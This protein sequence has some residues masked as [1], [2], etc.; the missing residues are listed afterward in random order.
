VGGISKSEFVSLGLFIGRKAGDIMKKI[1]LNIMLIVCIII[2]CLYLF[3]TQARAQWRTCIRTDLLGMELLI[4]EGLVTQTNPIFWTITPRFNWDRFG[5]PIQGK[6]P[7]MNAVYPASNCGELDSLSLR[8]LRS[9]NVEICGV[10]GKLQKNPN[11]NN[12]NEGFFADN[13]P[14][15][16][17]MY[18]EKNS[19]IS[20]SHF[21]VSNFNFGGGRPFQGNKNFDG[22]RVD[23]KSTNTE[24]FGNSSFRNIPANNAATVILRFNKS[25]SKFYIKISRVRFDEFI[26]GFNIGNPT[27]LLGD[28]INNNGKITV[29][30]EKG[31]YGTGTL[32]WEGIN[33]KIVRFEIGG[34]KGTAL[35]IDEFGIVP[36]R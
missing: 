4:S 11:P 1:I 2:F 20:P 3:Q 8:A 27:G 26:T 13:L 5:N 25:I 23:L 9:L 32:K 36:A 12:P 18:Q 15:V 16:L 19:Q 10:S 21:L 31:D 35:A 6:P 33:T 30:K 7:C 28:L 22:I 17:F 14:T 24:P 34:P 29:L